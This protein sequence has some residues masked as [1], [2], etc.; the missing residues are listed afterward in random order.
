MRRRRRR[1]QETP[2]KVKT[3]FDRITGR[4]MAACMSHVN[5]CL[6]GSMDWMAQ[7]ELA[8]LVLPQGLLDAYGVEQVDPKEVNL[9]PHLVLHAITLL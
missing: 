9:T 5:S 6:R 2:P 8:R 1:A 7:V 4:D 3:N